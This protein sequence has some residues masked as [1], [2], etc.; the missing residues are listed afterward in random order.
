MNFD[1]R[2]CVHTP[3]TITTPKRLG[4]FCRLYYLIYY[5]NVA[6]FSYWYETRE[7]A[8]IFTSFQPIRAENTMTL[9]PYFKGILLSLE[10]VG[11]EM[12]DVTHNELVKVHVK[13]L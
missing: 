11:L 3:L 13:F 8:K 10:R 5:R 12:L 2:L 6:E 1:C 9:N 7:R 4:S